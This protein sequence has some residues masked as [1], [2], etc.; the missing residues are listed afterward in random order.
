VFIGGR[1]SDGLDGAAEEME[2]D[3][4]HT[5]RAAEAGGGLGEL[6]LTTRRSSRLETRFEQRTLG[7][8]GGQSSGAGQGRAEQRA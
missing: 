4:H 7:K 3:Q 5:G 8:I 2:S 1:E 6:V